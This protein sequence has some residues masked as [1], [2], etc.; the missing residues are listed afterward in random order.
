M[1]AR[2]N[3]KTAAKTV[4]A[5]EHA[6]ARLPNANLQLMLDNLLMDWPVVHLNYKAACFRDEALV[7]L[8]GR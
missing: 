1:A 5:L 7:V 6:F 2:V 8:E 3:E 4:A